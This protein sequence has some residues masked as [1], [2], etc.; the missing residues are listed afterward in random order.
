MRKVASP[1]AVLLANLLAL[2]FVLAACGSPAPA[3]P[4]PGPAPDAIVATVTNQAQ[5]SPTEPAVATTRQITTSLAGVQSPAAANTTANLRAGPGT[6]FAVVGL[7]RPGQS[8]PLVARNP[9]GD[10]LQLEDARWI[11]AQL[12]AN[13]PNLPVA[14]VAGAPESAPP[15]APTA[16]LRSPTAGTLTVTV[17]DVG[18]GDSILIQTPDGHNALIDGGMAGMGALDYLHEHGVDRLDLV[19]ATHPHADHIGGLPEVLRALPVAQVA[20]NGQSLATPEY[21][22]FRDAARAAKA[23]YTEVKRGDRLAL[24]G[25]TLDVLS[26]AAARPAGDPNHNSLV[27]RL[28]YGATTFQFEGDADQDAEDE[29]R[30]AG[31]LKPVTFLKVGHHGGRTSSS[32]AFLAAVHPGVAVYSAMPFNPYGYPHAETVAN[33]EAVGAEIH[34][35]DREGSVVIT[36]D[37][38]GYRVTTSRTAAPPA[39]VAAPTQPS[40]PQ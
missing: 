11:S 23:R 40:A 36:S 14:E 1:L 33:L 10:W 35:T 6:G 24:G 21:E 8:L 7:A 37:G 20:A 3:L 22:A 16:G 19:V 25:L 12:V 5:T 13:A 38:A 2:A 29:M 32:P 34:G 9:A 31:V 26:P 4:W 18:Q 39:P 28:D 27:L 17:I 15:V 30:S